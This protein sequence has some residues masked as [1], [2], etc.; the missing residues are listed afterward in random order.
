MGK[1]VG[2]VG[3]SVLPILHSLILEADKV[4][5][6]AAIAVATRAIAKAQERHG[7][8]VLII[9]HLAPLLGH[10]ISR[11]APVWIDTVRHSLTHYPR[12]TLRRGSAGHDVYLKARVRAGCTKQRTLALPNTAHVRQASQAVYSSCEAQGNISECRLCV[13]KLFV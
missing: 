13:A 10:A 1:E 11:V 2:E 5:A 8:L 4:T 9:F 7:H 12:A 3:A 6:A